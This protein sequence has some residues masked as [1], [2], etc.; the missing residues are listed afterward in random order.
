M[1]PTMRV[2]RDRQLK[3][4]AAW[5]CKHVNSAE[6]T[7]S[8]SRAGQPDEHHRRFVGGAVECRA[9]ANS[10]IPPGLLRFLQQQQ[11]YIAI[12]VAIYAMFWAM[13]LPASFSVTLAYTLLLA[14]FTTL[15]QERLSYL[16]CNY[17]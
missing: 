16:Y 14:N 4:Q 17:K 2:R 11:L 13:G 3:S 15:V 8:G 12:A 7:P 10:V 5:A 1:F 9:M 6:Y